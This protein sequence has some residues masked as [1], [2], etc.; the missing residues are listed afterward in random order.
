[1][2][3]KQLKALL[4]LLTSGSSIESLNSKK[5]KSITIDAWMDQ[6]ENIV[7]EQTEYKQQTV[8]NRRAIFKHIRCLWG[9]VALDKIKPF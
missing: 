7:L 1:M 5:S 9:S 8:R 3:K 2:K 4:K 6:Y